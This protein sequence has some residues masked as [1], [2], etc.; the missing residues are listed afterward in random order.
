MSQIFAPNKP[1]EKYA[2]LNCPWLADILPKRAWPV[3]VSH[4]LWF[5]SEYSSWYPCVSAPGALK[6]PVTVV[7]PK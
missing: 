6:A 2:I 3:A 1:G 5:V 7:K 4:T